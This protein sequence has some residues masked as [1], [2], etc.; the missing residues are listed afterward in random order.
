M[1]SIVNNIKDNIIRNVIHIYWEKCGTKNGP[2]R[3]SRINPISDIPVKTS[4][5]EPPEAIYY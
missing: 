3:N 1:I 2:F 4:H 5:P